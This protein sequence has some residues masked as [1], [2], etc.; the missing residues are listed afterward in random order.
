VG[1]WKSTLPRALA[2]PY[3][4]TGLNFKR[5]SQGATYGGDVQAATNYPLVQITNR[6]SGQ[7]VYARTH[8]HSPMAIASTT[9]ASTN[10]DLNFKIETA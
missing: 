4:I 1:V 2:T 5:F 7:V 8:D 10:F 6:M 9:P 3:K